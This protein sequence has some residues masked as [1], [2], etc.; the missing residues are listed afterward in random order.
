MPV[1]TGVKERRSRTKVFVD[2]EFWAELDSGFVAE[3]GFY[4][5]TAL[6]HEE[7]AEARVAGERPLAMSRALHSLAF[8]ARSAHELRERLARARYAGQ[9]VSEVLDRLG[10]LGYLDDEEFARNAARDKA[11]KRYGPRRIYGELRQAGVDEEVA[12]E[13]VEEEFAGRSELEEA[14]AAVRRRYNTEERSVAQAR[15]VHGFLMRRG[16]SAGVSAEIARS[17]RRETDE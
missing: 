14:R 7:L 17:Y 16:Y 11:R 2:G 6:S 5:G 10:E 9:T 3:R 13:V 8:R 15:R 4:E 1:I 12:Q